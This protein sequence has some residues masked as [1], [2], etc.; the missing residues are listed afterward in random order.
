MSS[1]LSRLSFTLAAVLLVATSCTH[2]EDPGP[3]WEDKRDFAVMDFDRIEM[4]SGFRI[5]VEQSSSFQVEAH[6]DSRNL[7]DLEVFVN[8]GTLIARFKNS[9][10]RKHS[11]RI[12]IRMPAL[13]SVNLSGGTYSKIEEFES[14][15]QLDFYLSG[16]SLCELEAGY[17]KINLVLSGASKL[18]IEGLGDEMTAEISGASE[19]N[20]FE[21][22]VRAAAVNVSGASYGKVTVSDDL[23]AKATGAS[24]LLYRGS[25]AVQSDV[26]GASSI[27][28]D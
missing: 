10:N 11:T 12:E 6:G 9:V 13:T 22:P 4:G 17:R 2:T 14:D 27:A 3:L 1:Y 15:Q 25:P 28:K 8:G 16:G 20:A 23:D 24:R 18:D 21:Y 5:E 26:S 7:D 19:L